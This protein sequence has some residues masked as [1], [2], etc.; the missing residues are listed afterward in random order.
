MTKL[1]D[2]LARKKAL[3][4]LETEYEYIIRSQEI[5]SDKLTVNRGCVVLKPL[6]VEAI[7]AVL[8]STLNCIKYDLAAIN[9]KINAINELLGE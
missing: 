6:D 8:Q 1:N 4:L 3:E 2:I 7:K 9:I 5:G